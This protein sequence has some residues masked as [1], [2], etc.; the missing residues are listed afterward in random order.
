MYR[1][2]ALVC[3][4]YSKQETLATI[5]YAVQPNFLFIVKRKVPFFLNLRRLYHG[6]K[7]GSLPRFLTS[8]DQIPGGGLSVFGLL[9]ANLLPLLLMLKFRKTV[10]LTLGWQRYSPFLGAALQIHVADLTTC[11]HGIRQRCV[12]WWFQLPECLRGSL[13][14]L[15]RLCRAVP[16]AKI[17]HQLKM[18]FPHE[19][20]GISKK[21]KLYMFNSSA[22][23]T[24][25][26]TR[27][28]NASDVKLPCF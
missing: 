12:E 19:K 14:V 17:V 13:W 22:R 23:G 27:I 4:T 20:K 6:R 21:K 18:I 1:I 11:T 8:P 9:S 2:L 15:V 16:C 26:S 10:R 28:E 5:W 3:W 25:I 7:H 24:K